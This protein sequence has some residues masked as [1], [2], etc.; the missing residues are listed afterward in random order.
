MTTTAPLKIAVLGASGHIGRVI[1][2]E[3]VSRGHRVTAVA[4]DAGRL[5]D[6]DGVT[7]VSA[8]VLDAQAL[9]AAVAGHD[10]V[11]AALAGRG[12]GQARTVPDAARLLL[13][14]LPSAGVG[15][16]IFSGGGGSLEAVPGKRLMDDPH[17][18]QQYKQEAVA[19]A[20]ALDIFRSSTSDVKWTYVSPPPVYLT[21]GDR[22]GIYRAEATDQPIPGHDGE[23]RISV[24]DLACAIVDSAENATFIGQRITTAY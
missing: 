1:T 7:A 8:D 15:R 13:E 6:V 4:R 18:P 17:F 19:A 3:A 12:P 2:E 24:A 23:S 22:T 9:A 14:V 16:L 21:D 11:I 5:N 10:A 20:E